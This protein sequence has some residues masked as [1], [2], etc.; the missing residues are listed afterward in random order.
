MINTVGN[1]PNV[2]KC[3]QF[4]MKWLYIIRTGMKLFEVTQKLNEDVPLCPKLNGAIVA[5]PELI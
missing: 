4:L 5:W 3:M 1:S 2:S